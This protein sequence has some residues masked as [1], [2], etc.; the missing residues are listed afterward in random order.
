MLVGPGTLLIVGIIGGLGAAAT[1]T[2]YAYVQQRGPELTKSL[3]SDLS[4]MSPEDGPP[5]PQALNIRW[6]WR[7]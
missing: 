6:P 3:Q 7:R 1:Y 4:P 2:S 5:L